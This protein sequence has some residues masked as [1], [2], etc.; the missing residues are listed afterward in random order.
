MLLSMAG[1]KAA[2][3]WERIS[4]GRRSRKLDYSAIVC[5]AMKLADDEGI[6]AVSMR[7]VAEAL[8][9]GTMSLYRYVTGKD[10]LLDLILDAAYGEIPLQEAS[11]AD[12]RKHLRVVAIETRQVLKEHKWLALLIS[13]RP[14][15]GPNYLRWFEFLLA[16]T[17]ASGRSMRTRARV[18]GTLWA[19]I[20]GFIA[21]ELGE[22]ETNRRYKLTEAKK[23]RM[24]QPYLTQIIATGKYPCLTEFL[25]IGIGQPTDQDFKIGLDAV[26]AGIDSLGP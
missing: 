12:W 20:S 7:K 5:A 1:Q 22:I 9:V 23:R 4:A 11:G 21:Y 19:Y 17:G 25:K 2:L 3:I 8:G 16:T 13:R 18:I 6:E 14:T 24:V 15:L 10:D 26:L